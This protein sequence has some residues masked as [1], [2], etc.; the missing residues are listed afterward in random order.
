MLYD[1]YLVQVFIPLTNPTPFSLIPSLL[2][3]TKEEEAIWFEILSFFLFPSSQITLQVIIL[4]FLFQKEK[5]SS[6]PKTQSLV[7]VLN[8]LDLNL[9]NILLFIFLLMLKF[10]IP[11]GSLMRCS[12]FLLMPLLHLRTHTSLVFKLPF[13]TITFSFQLLPIFFY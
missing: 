5:R 4:P 12:S 1:G 2:K 6:L 10:C 11:T 8:Y 13:E 3:H 9:S 7:S